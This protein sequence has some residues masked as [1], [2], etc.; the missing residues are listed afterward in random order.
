MTDG[1]NMERFNRKSL[2]ENNGQIFLQFQGGEH[3]YK[4]G[5]KSRYYNGEVD[6]FEC[7]KIRNFYKVKSNTGEGGEQDKTFSTYGKRLM[8]MIMRAWKSSRKR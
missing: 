2:G 1:G 5:A 6:T 8:P 3:T 4:H 7:I